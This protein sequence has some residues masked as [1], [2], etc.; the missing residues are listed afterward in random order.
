MDERMQRLRSRLVEEWSDCRWSRRDQKRCRHLTPG[1]EAQRQAV[2]WSLRGSR[3]DLLV[4]M[5][6]CGEV[7]E[8]DNMRQCRVPLCP[9]CL[10]LRRGG[11]TKRMIREEFAG[12]GNDKL[13]LLTVLMPVDENLSSMTKI[14]ARADTRMRNFIVRQREKDARWNDVHLVGYWE[15]DRLRADEIAVQGRNT[16]LFL[17]QSGVPVTA[18][19]A[20]LWLPHFHAIVALGDVSREGFANALRSYGYNASYQVDLRAFDTSR[21]VN[22]NLKSIV[23]Y[24]NKFRVEHDFKGVPVFEDADQEEP[25]L[26]KRNWWPQEDIRAYAGWLSGEYSGFQSMRLRIGRKQS[27]EVAVTAEEDVSV[28]KSAVVGHNELSE[29]RG[30]SVRYSNMVQDTNWIY[31]NNRR[32]LAA[33]LDRNLIVVEDFDF[34]CY[35]DPMPLHTAGT[36]LA[37]TSTA[38]SQP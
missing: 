25:I 30:L 7:D 12:V 8:Q 35:A 6:G 23:R 31:R 32:K 13:A 4:R 9:R 21:E 28:V 5:Q 26:F 17:R 34:G 22:E 19:D 16:R 3:E 38:Q 15:L 10:M 2:M 36:V 14:M 33:A 11:E 27:K 20:T 24:A 18:S 1:M 37:A 29:D